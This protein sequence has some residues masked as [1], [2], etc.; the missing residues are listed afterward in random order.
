[1]FLERV[2][3]VSRSSQTIIQSRRHRDTE[4]LC[5]FVSLWLGLSVLSASSVSVTA[6]SSTI[7]ADLRAI[8]A[9]P[10]E[11]SLVSAGGITR[12]DTAM[13]T[14]ENPSP[15]DAT[16]TV[17]RLVLIGGFDGDEASARAVM[18]AVRW[19]KSEAPAAVRRSWIVSAMP[20]ANPDANT[21]PLEFPPGKGF[22]DDPQVPESRY[23]WRWLS[24]Q[25]PD[26]VVVFSAQG[27]S[28]PAASLTQ[29]LSAD[30]AAGLGPVSV[31]ES[32]TSPG[33]FRTWLL[34]A[35]APAAAP[36]GAPSP[37]HEAIAKRVA[38]ETLAIARQL[39]Q[40]YP[41]TPAISYIPSVAWVDT[42]RLAALTGDDALRTKVREQTRPWVSGDKALFGDRIQLTAVA[43]TMIFADLAA[44]GDTSAQPLAARG[45]DLA[46][47][48]KADGALEYGQGWTDDMFMTSSI[49]SRVSPGGAAALLIEYASRL[50]RPDGLFNH[51]VN[52]PA[53][54]GRGNGFA[55]FG[56]T[57]ALTTIPAQDPQRPKL[58]EIF[59][60]HMTAVR[61]HQAPDGAWRQV[62][63]E[64]GAY[65][66]ETATAMLLAA[67][68]R[69]IRFGWIDGSFRSTVERAW[70]ALAAH[71]AEDGTLVDVCTST[72]AG[73]T[74]R[75]YL[76]RA[77][78]SG[79]DDR[80]GAMALRAAVEM[81]ELKR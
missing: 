16:T 15:F 79:A 81:I 38:R 28:V 21:A 7:D 75:Y 9:L 4:I 41:E 31:S 23:L 42:L 20:L 73:P 13:S 37:L 67:M 61:A 44:A 27:S 76:D 50:Q 64:P 53:A 6:L 66:E 49:V 32:G 11:P 62:I 43:G 65:R 63:D 29:A 2:H 72:G 22:F 60:R 54:W 34:A 56:L 46:R 19:I 5:V 33:A 25:A 55:A 30:Q 77:A 35:T 59:Q 10:G 14:L 70:R 3:K 58:L 78:L 17:R 68:A 39:A 51:A 18:E 8:A 69:G 1:M 57:E 47:A 52:G 71:I 40:R 74:R 12:R 26:H 45:A 36:G 48:K 80:G 24:Y